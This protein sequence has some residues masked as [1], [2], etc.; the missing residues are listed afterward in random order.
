MTVQTKAQSP[1]DM[2]NVSS[3]FEDD[4]IEPFDIDYQNR[5]LNVFITDRE[6]FPERIIDIVHVDYFDAYQK[7]LLDYELNFFSKY[8]EVA[9]FSTLRDIISEKEKGLN[10]DHL[11]GLLEHIEQIKLENIEHV[12]DSSYRFFK[13]RSIKN[14]LFELVVDWKKHNYDSMKVKL[15]NA[16]KAGEPKETGHNYLRDVAK[17]LEKDFREPIS[18]IPSLDAFI[19]GG[20]SAGEM[21]FVLAPTGGGKSMFLVAGAATAL[22]AGKKAVYYTLELSE[23]VVGQRFDS[24]INQ[25]NLRT[26]WEFA[27]V[28]QER[29]EELSKF[30]GSLIIKEFLTGQATINTLMAHLRTLETNDG[31]KPD[32]VFIDYGD[33]LKPLDSFAEKRHSLDSIYVGIRGMANEFR[34]PIW[35]AL[36]T[37]RT[38]MDT[39]KVSLSTVGE[40]LG[41]LR[42]AD[43]VISVGREPDRDPQEVL[44]NPHAAKIGILKNRNGAAGFYLDAI[45]DP[46]KIFIDIIQPDPSVVGVPQK[47]NKSTKTNK[48]PEKKD[49]SVDDIEDSLDNVM[50]S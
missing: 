48:K 6:G 1:K 47:N 22:M 12:K 24:C 26:V 11:I 33:L 13:E 30:G 4:N 46:S 36:Q 15:E 37:N 41:A 43:I 29:A 16:L 34:I 31:F 17:R 10:K 19:G 42:A 7:I 3:F 5:F 2:G 40:T 9:R 44:E 35:S 39:D 14:C 18:F 49:S 27:D 23:E 28:I 38:G 45:F 50:L 32:I 20:A 25:L 21:A 8:R